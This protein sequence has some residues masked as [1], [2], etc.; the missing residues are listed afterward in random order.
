MSSINISFLV[1]SILMIVVGDT[2]RCLLGT[3]RLVCGWFYGLNGFTGLTQSIV[4]L[5]EFFETVV[6]N[7]QP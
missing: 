7:G 4:I 3:L 5:S 2:N 1:P 6:E